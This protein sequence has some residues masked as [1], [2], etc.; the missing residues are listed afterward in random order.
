MENDRAREIAIAAGLTKLDDKHMAQL[1]NSV[2]SARDVG[3]KLPKD[4]HWSEEIAL[5]FRLS[6]PKDV[7]P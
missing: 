7:Q 3:G 2:A 4:L 1:A 6:D 5:V